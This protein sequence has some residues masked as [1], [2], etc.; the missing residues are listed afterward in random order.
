MK[1]ATVGAAMAL[2]AIATLET[3]CGPIQ[4]SA[5]VGESLDGRSWILFAYRKTKPL[6]GTE[7]TASFEDGQITGA[8]GCNSYFGSY[9]VA[10]GA[11]SIGTVGSTEMACMDPEGVMEQEQEYLEHLSDAQ[12]FQL[13]GD[14]LTIYWDEHEALTFVSN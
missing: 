4:N 12:R 1:R 8:A 14:Q 5:A 6:A 7:I 10:G 3:A 11:I 2:V 9:E 13:D